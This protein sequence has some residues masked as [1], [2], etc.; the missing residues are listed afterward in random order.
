SYGRSGVIRRPSRIATVS[1]GY[2]DGLPRAA[3]NGRF[4]LLVRGQR[5]PIIGNVCMDMCMIDITH[6]PQAAEGDEVVVFGTEPTAEEL[7]RAL[8]TIPY[9]V[10]T[11][12]S[13]RV[14]RVYVQE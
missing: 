6:I 3:G 4:S 13:P 8:G 14:R 9:E 7:A 12:V 1:I 5:A 11:S 2:A 10:F